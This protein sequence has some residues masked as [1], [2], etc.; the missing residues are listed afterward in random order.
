MIALVLA[1]GMALTAWSFITVWRAAHLDDASRVDRADAIVVLGAAQYNGEPSPVFRGRLEHA[2]L[3]WREQRASLVL[4]LGSN[5]P[6]DRSTEGAAGRDYLIAQGVPAD[7]VVSIP[8]GTTSYQS[9]QAAATY[10]RGKDLHSVFLVSDPWHNARIKKMA[11]DLGLQAYASATWTSA[12]QSR[13][14]RLSGYV[15]ETFAYLYY[16]IVGGD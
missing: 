9:L 12:Y 2:A 15:R 10:L 3:M 4:V 6:G 7:G 5:R 16:R 8:E 14:A 1:G 11:T 13:S